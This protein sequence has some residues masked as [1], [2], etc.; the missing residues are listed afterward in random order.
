MNKQN[1]IHAVQPCL[2][3]SPDERVLAIGGLDN[4]VRLW[5]VASARVRREFHGHEA[6]ACNLTFSPDGRLLASASADTTMLIWS[7][8][9]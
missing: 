4:S 7:T 2:A 5:E 6:P 3:W 1:A 8:N 9:R